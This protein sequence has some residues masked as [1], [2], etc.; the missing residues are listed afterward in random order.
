MK[1]TD[2]TRFAIKLRVTEKSCCRVVEDVQK[3]WQ[4]AAELKTLAR[5]IAQQKRT[6]R[7]L[8]QRQEDRIEK[9]EVLE[10]II[11]HIVKFHPLG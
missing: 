6:Q 7:F 5:N 9:F 2:Y 4:D 1:D 10:V 8:L 11:D 3:S